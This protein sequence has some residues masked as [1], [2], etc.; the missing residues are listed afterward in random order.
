MAETA[1][2]AAHLANILHSS[3]YIFDVGCLIAGYQCTLRRNMINAPPIG[4]LY[5]HNGDL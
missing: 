3:V 4:R 1:S 2:S 5:G